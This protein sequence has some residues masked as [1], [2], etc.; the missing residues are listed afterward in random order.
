MI[1]VIQK[2]TI[3]GFYANETV[4]KKRVNNISTIWEFDLVRNFCTLI[5]VT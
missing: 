2:R 4:Q 3:L 1:K 5:I